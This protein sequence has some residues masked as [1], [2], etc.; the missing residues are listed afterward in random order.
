[1]RM[2]RFL[3]V[4]LAWGLGFLSVAAAE[5]PVG[6]WVID[7]QAMR[8]QMRKMVEKQLADL[9][10]EQRKL[11]ESMID[12]QMDQ[13]LA[14]MKGSA[15]F[16]ADGSVVFRDEKGREDLGVWEEKD[17]QIRLRAKDRTGGTLVGRMVDGR[18]HM[19]PEEDG[20]AP[21]FFVL[22]RKEG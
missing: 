8:G 11:A 12:A 10:P 9:T 2:I 13:V 5:S 1:M 20:D 3:F 22:K 19:R 4:V 18:L 14:E 15:E 7:S 16:R 17:G 6:T 21:F